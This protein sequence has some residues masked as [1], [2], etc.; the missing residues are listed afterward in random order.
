[1][2]EDGPR[3]LDWALANMGI[4]AVLGDPAYRL[5][6]AARVKTLRDAGWTYPEIGEKIGTSRQAA[7]NLYLENEREREPDPGDLEPV[8]YDRAHLLAEYTSGLTPREL[9]AQHQVGLQTIFSDLGDNLWSRTALPGTDA[10]E[11]DRPEVAARI[12]D[13]ITRQPLAIMVKRD[14]HD[15]WD[16]SRIST[17][18]EL[19]AGSIQRLINAADVEILRRK[20][21]GEA[22]AVVA[23]GLGV[24]R[25]IAA[26]W[27]RT[28]EDNQDA[29]A[30]MTADHAAGL[31][32]EEPPVDL[33]VNDAVLTAYRQ[34]LGNAL[35]ARRRGRHLTAQT[36]ALR[37]G[38]S[39][40]GVTTHERGTRE[41]T[42]ES[43]LKYA[44]LYRV[45]PATLVR[46]AFE[47]V[48]SLAPRGGVVV[49]LAALAAT[50]RPD[51][52]P[53]CAWARL[54]MRDA[55]S[56]DR[57]RIHI[58][59]AALDQLAALSG[60]G[61]DQLIAAFDEITTPERKTDG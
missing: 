56:I 3:G 59:V 40:Q 37:I 61:P 16:V 51:L 12:A 49:D 23:A 29:I 34:A 7:R 42:A 53:L 21:A 22:V 18:Y 48:A 31:T 6:L 50:T 46:E 19:T 10:V 27:L 36:V 9:R 38:I 15:G 45:H 35:R 8:R 47:A 39:S 44:V 43:L 4:A 2:T 32:V 54:R 55:P 33:E 13:P 26:E 20:W 41:V 30:A 60:L 14:H 25:E 52:A 24:S 58:D 28:A 57:A 17:E 11:R 1:V 5:L